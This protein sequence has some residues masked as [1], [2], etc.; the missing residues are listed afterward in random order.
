MGLVVVTPPALEPLTLAEAKAHLRV[1]S[2]FEDSLITAQITAARQY[3]EETSLWRALITQTL[4]LTG[5]K[6]PTGRKPL[7]LPRPNL[8]TVTSITYFDTAGVS[9]TWDAAKYRVVTSSAPGWVEPVDTEVYP[10][11]YDRPDG[12]TVNYT[13]GY[14]AAATDVPELIRRALLILIHDLFTSRGGCAFDQN[15]AANALLATYRVRDERT[16]IYL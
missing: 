7:V 12:F 3:A 16:L 8:L 15:I 10:D 2:T 5:R 13:A 11:T 4:R 1:D 14:G 9:Q 6:F